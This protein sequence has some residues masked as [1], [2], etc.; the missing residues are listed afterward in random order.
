MKAPRF[1][2][3][4][5]C[6]SACALLLIGCVS[7]PRFAI[8]KGKAEVIAGTVSAD[9]TQ[10]KGIVAFSSSRVTVT[11]FISDCKKGNGSLRIEGSSYSEPIDNLI[12]GASNPADQVFSQLCREG[13]PID[14][15]NEQERDRRWASMTPEQ[16]EAERGALL[17]LLQLQLTAQRNASRNASQERAAKELADA[18]RDSKKSTTE[19]REVG[20]SKVKCETK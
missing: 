20:A 17:Q 6:T 19:C 9:L 11:T 13:L 16:R 2:S 18:I 3:V 7:S 12:V 1:L 15:R 14:A 5:L 10:V 8:L 4:Y